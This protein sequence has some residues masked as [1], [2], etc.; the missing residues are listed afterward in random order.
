MNRR[1]KT[2]LSIGTIVIVVTIIVTC[3]CI[4]DWRGLTPLGMAFIVWSEL[5]LFG[6]LIFVERMSENTE[7]TMLRAS[8]YVTLTIYSSCAFIISVIFILWLKYS[9]RGF[10]IIHLIFAAIAAI[11]LIIFSTTSKSVYLSNIK[12]LNATNLIEGYSGRLVALVAI[13]GNS[14]YI[15][16]VKK[17]AEDLRFT[18]TSTVVSVDCEIEM[19]ISELEVEFSKEPTAQS[20][21]IIKTKIT[22]LNSLIAKRKVGTAALKKGGI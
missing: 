8:Y 12:T 13:M 21:D 17:A 20:T 1:S 11:L 3:L 5:A 6:G 18:D 7:Q 16:A 14:E 4:K 22:G 15:P 9:I 2:L 19:V 10:I